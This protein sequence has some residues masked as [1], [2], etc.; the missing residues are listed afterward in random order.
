MEEDEEGRCESY[1]VEGVVAPSLLLPQQRLDVQMRVLSCEEI[2][3]SFPL[4]QARS[5]PVPLY[6]ATSRTG[7]HQ[8]LQVV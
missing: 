7:H 3:N 6:G 1:G 8:G 2:R 5:Y 4:G